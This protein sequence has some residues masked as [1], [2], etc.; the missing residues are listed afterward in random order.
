MSN[1]ATIVPTKGAGSKG[2]AAAE[3]IYGLIGEFDSVDAVIRAAR[4]V[5]K[6]GYTRFDVHS[7]FPIHGIDAAMGIRPTVLPKIVLAC[8]AFGCLAGLCLATFTMAGGSDMAV[9][10]PWGPIQGYPFMISGKPLIS[11]P[12]FIPVIFECTILFSALGAVFGMLFLNTLPKLYH[13]LFK[14]ERFRR[15]TSD[16]FFVAIEALDGQFEQARTSAFL[17]AQGALSVEVIEE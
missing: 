16:R 6:A 7:P 10:S 13:P 14:S 4:A 3:G 8:G 15:S 12:A 1:T 9:P 5:R 17:Q 11:M 2:A